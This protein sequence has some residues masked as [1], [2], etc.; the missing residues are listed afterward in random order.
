MDWADSYNWRANVWQKLLN[1]VIT[2]E[3]NMIN[4]ISNAMQVSTKLV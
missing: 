2:T 4:N 3:K 1:T